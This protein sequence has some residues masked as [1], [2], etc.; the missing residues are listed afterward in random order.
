MVAS[1]QHKKEALEAKIKDKTSELRKLCIEEA[2]ITG[3]LPV[4]TPLEP[5]ESPPQFRRRIGTSFTYPES[6]I[7]KLKCKEVIYQFNYIF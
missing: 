1:L 5:G 4:E 3:I 2:E 6:L 7:N